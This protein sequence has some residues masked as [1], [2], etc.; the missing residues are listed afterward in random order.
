MNVNVRLDLLAKNRICAYI[1]SSPFFEMNEEEIISFFPSSWTDVFLPFTEFLNPYMAREISISDHGSVVELSFSCGTRN[2]RTKRLKLYIVSPIYNTNKS[3]EMD[4]EVIRSRFIFTSES[5]YSYNSQ[6]DVIAI[7]EE[8]AVKD[9]RVI[10]DTNVAYYD[11]RDSAQ[12]RTLPDN[13]FFYY[14]FDLPH[15]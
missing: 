7:A 3:T 1:F 4:A 9:A 8:P 6:H 15:S 14:D 11:Q 12:P 2:R 5:F 10:R 13:F